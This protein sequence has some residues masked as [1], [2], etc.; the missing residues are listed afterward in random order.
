MQRPAYRYKLPAVFLLF[1]VLFNFPVI[2]IFNSPR[3]VLGIPVLY[4]YLLVAWLG[5]VFLMARIIHSLNK[6]K[7]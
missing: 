4:L 1:L 5:F 3:L 2:A 6:A 7:K